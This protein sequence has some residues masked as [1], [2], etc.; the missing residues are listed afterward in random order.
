M[1]SR[2]RRTG[3]KRCPLCDFIYEDDQGLCEMDGIELVQDCEALIPADEDTVHGT[4]PPAGSPRR[5]RTLHLILG[6]GLGAVVFSA[7]YTSVNQAAPTQPLAS[8][9]GLPAP[10]GAEP[11]PAP[12]A[13]ISPTPP[14][15]APVL[16]AGE[17]TPMPASVAPATEPRA[18]SPGGKKPPPGGGGKKKESKLASILNKTGR[19]LK[20]PFGF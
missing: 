19:M 20:K 9:A 7:Y 13:P 12:A 5:R 11:T 2:R 3:M 16:T 14:A 1:L 17:T 18:A 6:F 8:Y 15:E 10:A 4:P